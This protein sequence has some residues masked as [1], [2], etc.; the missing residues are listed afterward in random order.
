ML[1]SD[2]AQQALREAGVRVTA[3][4]MMIVDVLVGNRTHPTVE[5]IY[6]RI[7]DTCPTISL[8]TVYHTLALLARQGLILELRGAKDGLHC[9]PDTTPHAHAYCENCGKVFD[10]PLPSSP[11]WDSDLLDGFHPSRTELSLY[12]RCGNC[13]E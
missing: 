12:G 8:A 7:R 11:A 2:V 10:I 9:D 1:A 3:Q 6:T 13:K 4:R 5:E